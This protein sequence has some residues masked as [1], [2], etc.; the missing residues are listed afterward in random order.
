MSLLQYILP[1]Q[2][3]NY[4][5]GCG[6]LID[7][8]F[9]TPGH[10][11]RDSENPFIFLS[12]RKRYLTQPSFYEVNEQDASKYDLAVFSMPEVKSELKLY[13]GVIESGMKL[14]S[15]SF[16][17]ST[18]GFDLIECDAFVECYKQQNYFG[19]LTNTH[20]K[21]GCSGGPAIIGNEVVGILTKGNNNGN[22][23][24]CNN[25][26]PINFC[27]FLSSKAIRRII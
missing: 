5:D 3:T 4:V 2:N 12:K 23:E 1:I 9:I 26:L 13:N 20:L 19:A 24:P 17:T 8:Y 25:M 22:N 18:S 14:K 16:K 11:I 10:V 6:F 27:L 15:I 7:G 21:A